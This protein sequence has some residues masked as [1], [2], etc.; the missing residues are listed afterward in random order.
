[1]SRSSP[2]SSM[3]WPNSDR[4]SVLASWARNRL[5]VSAAA[6]AGSSRWAPGSTAPPPTAASVTT[7]RPATGERPGSPSNAA[8]SDTTSSGVQRG[9]RLRRLGAGG[10]LGVERL[11]LVRRRPMA[12]PGPSAS[13]RRSSNVRNS[14]KL[15]SRFTSAGFGL[16]RQIGGDLDRS[17]PPQHHH[18]VVLADPFLVLDERGAQLRRLLVDVGEDAVE[19]A[20]RG[21]QLGRRLL[22]HA[23]HAGQVVAGI[24]AQR[25]VL[26][27]TAPA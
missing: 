6:T 4:M 12:A 24:A 10:D 27:G 5:A 8:A 7:A 14:R 1:M 16:H 2:V 15:N 23:R 9:Q 22:P 25:G 21:D 18:L 3:P 13:A 26:A 11:A 20:V 19:P 17:V